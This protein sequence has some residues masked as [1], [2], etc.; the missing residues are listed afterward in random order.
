MPE[1]CAHPPCKCLASSDDVYCS[2]ICAMLGGKLVDRVKVSS[3]VALKPDDQVE[4]RCPCGHTA[5]AE[6]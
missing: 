1:R 3:D 6:S 4:V 5:C 2:D